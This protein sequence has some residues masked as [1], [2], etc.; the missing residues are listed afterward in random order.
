[1]GELAWEGLMPLYQYA[2]VYNRPLLFCNATLRNQRMGT[3]SILYYLKATL[4]NEIKESELF[5]E[6]IVLLGNYTLLF[7]L[8]I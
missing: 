4:A 8:F 3:P 6:R 1:V 5:F 7:L 2:E